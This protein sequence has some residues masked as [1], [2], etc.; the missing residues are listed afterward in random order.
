MEWYETDDFVNATPHRRNHNGNHQIIVAQVVRWFPVTL[1]ATLLIWSYY[2]FVI[3]L[4]FLEM[5]NMSMQIAY[6]VPYHVILLFL[7]TCFIKTIFTPP[8]STPEYWRL[9][10]EVSY[11]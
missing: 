2:V 10:D 7:A 9:S 4:T 8:G 5:S 6:L 3:K 1:I 11:F